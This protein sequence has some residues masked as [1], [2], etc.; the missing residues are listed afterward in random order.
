MASNAPTKNDLQ[1]TSDQIR[2]ILQDVCQP[3]SGRGT[4]PP[5]SDALEENGDLD[6]DEDDDDS[7]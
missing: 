7:D 1:D 3:K 6:E 2:S 5:S 4:S